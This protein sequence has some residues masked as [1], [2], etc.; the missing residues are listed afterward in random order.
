MSPPPL[1]FPLVQGDVGD[2][3]ALGITEALKLKR[4]V[5]LSAVEASTM[6]LRVDDIVRCAPRKREEGDGHSH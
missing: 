3:Q 5:L 2:M 6:I 4:Q 1:I